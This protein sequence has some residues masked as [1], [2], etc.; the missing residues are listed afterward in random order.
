M[1][2]EYQSYIQKSGEAIDSLRES[3]YAELYGPSEQ[4]QSI[5]EHLQKLDSLSHLSVIPLHVKEVI[6]SR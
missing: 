3:T 5:R 1:E 2:E 6:F 4:T